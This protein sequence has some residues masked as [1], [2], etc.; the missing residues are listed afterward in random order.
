M[1]DLSDLAPPA[2]DAS[3]R[4]IRAVFGSL[5]PGPSGT[6][7]PT[8]LRWVADWLEHRGFVEASRTL[9]ASANDASY[10]LAPHGLAV[11]ASLR[12]L[13]A[14]GP[15]IPWLPGV[16]GAIY[17][18]E[19][20]LHLESITVGTLEIRPKAP[21]R[22]RRILLSATAAAS[23]RS[24]LDEIHVRRVAL[25]GVP[26]VDTGGLVAGSF[27]TMAGPELVLGGE[28]R[29]GA[30]LTL[31][32]GNVAGETLLVSACALGNPLG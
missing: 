18:C 16:Y 14:T 17:G 13:L 15:E 27:F 31:Q 32:L 11:L 19:A 9:R 10:V 3:L 29:A 1:T 7:D 23:T 5:T 12:E 4:T 21:M 6:Y 26:V 22:L 8:R 28:I 2:V 25:D 20:L 30:S 24:R